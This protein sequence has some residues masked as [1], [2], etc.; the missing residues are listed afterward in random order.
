M[1]AHGRLVGLLT[2]LPGG[3]VHEL[4][5][6]VLR[7]VAVGLGGGERLHL[8]HHLLVGEELGEPVGGQHQELVLRPDAVVAQ[9]RRA[10]HV[11]LR[12]HVVDLEGFQKPAVPLGLPQRERGKKINKR[13]QNLGVCR[14][15]FERIRTT[16]KT[17]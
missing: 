13:Q 15:T 1:R 16:I 17:Q 7:G 3:A 8:V 10:A 12:A 5:D 4:A 11:R 9:R 6:E 2:G 14:L